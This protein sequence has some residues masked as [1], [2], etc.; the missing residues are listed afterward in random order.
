MSSQSQMG[1]SVFVNAYRQKYMIQISYSSS[2]ERSLSQTTWLGASGSTWTL[3]FSLFCIQKLV[4]LPV[5]PQRVGSAHPGVSLSPQSPELLPHR[6]T[7]VLLFTTVSGF[8]HFLTHVSQQVL[9]VHTP[10]SLKPISCLL[11]ILPTHRT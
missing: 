10:V 2:H 11:I 3:F 7:R 9:A 5:P 4:L 6:Q 1:I 8:S